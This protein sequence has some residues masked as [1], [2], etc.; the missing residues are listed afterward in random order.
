MPVPAD[1]HHPRSREVRALRFIEKYY[2]VKKETARLSVRFIAGSTLTFG[3]LIT[4]SIFLKNEEKQ[5]DKLQ[6]EEM[7]STLSHR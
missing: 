2:R 3:L 5:T 1:E 6:I 4:E 7:T